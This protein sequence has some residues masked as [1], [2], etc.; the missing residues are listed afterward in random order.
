MSRTEPPP[1]ATWMLEHCA[2]GDCNEALAGDLREGF[3][4]GLS[5]GWYWRQVIAAC[6]VAWSESLRVRTPLLIFTLLW[7]M[8]APAWKVFIDGIESAPLFRLPEVF[9]GLWIFPAF[10]GWLLLN[11][12][13]LWAGILVYQLSLW[14]FGKAFLGKK[15]KRALLLAPFVYAPVFG[16]SFALC[17]LDWAAP[18]PG[19]TLATTPLGQ[20]AD[21]GMLA[22][23]IRFPYCIT[24]LCVLW[25]AIPRSIHN[26]A[27]AEVASPPIESSTEADVPDLVSTGDS[28]AE[29]RFIGFM[30]LCGLINAMIA[31]IL[32][33]RL[34]EGDLPTF[35]TLLAR[36]IL[37]DV[38]VVLAGIAGS[39][40]YW[41]NPLSP[42]RERSPIPF[43]LFAL[44]CASGWIWVP[45]MA[46]FLDQL[47]P[48]TALVAIIGA[49]C[50]AAGLRSASS[51]VFAPAE[52]NTAGYELEDNELFASALYRAPWEIRGYFVAFLFYAGGC[53]L[54][55]R[56]T[57][58]A[59][60]FLALGS[61]LFVWTRSSAPAHE[62]DSARE[63]R[64]AALRL[65]CVA[66]P[67]VLITVWSLLGG[68]TQRNG[69]AA[70]NAVAGTGNRGCFINTA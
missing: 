33:G 6:A 1:I 21:W 23:F 54:V 29:K 40:L 52:N 37:H 16:A 45:S 31:G 53:A 9:G 11:G 28:Y 57:L 65:A 64:R 5:E 22:D 14:V 8:M 27:L 43:P 60:A 13:F 47:S 49:A 4:S 12:T 51:T 30:V 3:S 24:L 46:I 68:M 50:L 59:A 69:L 67:G 55:M 42:Y 17:C 2:G 70:I 38:T 56:Q 35:S 19:G 26:Y 63:Y 36:S 15:I 41:K 20:V 61:F 34:L 66:L 7:S 44:V 18:L 10:A 32:F 58:L 62:L 25:N 48:A 39:W